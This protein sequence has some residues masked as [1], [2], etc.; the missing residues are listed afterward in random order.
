MCAPTTTVGT[1]THAH[2]PDVVQPQERLPQDHG[3]GR[4]DGDLA[5]VL[6][7][8][9]EQQAD[10]RLHAVLGIGVRKGGRLLLEE[11]LAAQALAAPPGLR[12]GRV[13]VGGGNRV[14]PGMGRVLATVGH[15]FL[16]RVGGVEWLDLV[17]P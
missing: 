4:R 14:G 10:V 6:E 8:V 12:Q 7:Q 3:L 11:E 1:T 5:S 2:L 15:S 9:L 13:V 17:G 16:L